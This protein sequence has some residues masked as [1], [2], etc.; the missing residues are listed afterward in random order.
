MKALLAVAMVAI[1]SSA[2]AETI[3]GNDVL[4]ACQDKDG[5][6]FEGFCTGYIIGSWEGMHWGTFE[7]YI[8]MSEGSFKVGEANE[9]ASTALRAC[10]P[11]NIENG[12]IKDI[13]IAYLTNHPETRHKS[14]RNLIQQAMM[15]AY[16][17]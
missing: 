4:Q 1:A 6:I 16:P 8:L 10:A 12:Q 13:V 7:A 2:T 3:S 11:T 15:G 5:G 9:F 17:C 14:A